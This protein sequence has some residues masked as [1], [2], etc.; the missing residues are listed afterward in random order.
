MDCGVYYVF[1]VTLRSRRT[2][3]MLAIEETSISDSSPATGKVV[4]TLG[5]PP[6]V[7][8]ILPVGMILQFVN[9]YVLR[10]EFY[11]VCSV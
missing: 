10:C 4:D 8:R 3:C 1:V 5:G 7:C 9:G 2:F 11:C 6:Q